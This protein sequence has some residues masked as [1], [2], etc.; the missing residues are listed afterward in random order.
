MDDKHFDRISR[1][2]GGDATRRGVLGMAAALTGLAVTDA[3]AKSK[4]RKRR[5]QRRRK[6]PGSPET[7]QDPWLP[8]PEGCA[9]ICEGPSV[10]ESL[11][12]VC[13]ASVPGT[14]C[15]KEE[16]NP[17]SCAETKECPHGQVCAV[18]ECLRLC[19]PDD[20]PE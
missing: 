14:V 1:L 8:V 7:C 2:L 18:N 3:E 13:R 19:Q 15:V 17:A 9:R 12:C 5:R 6:G 4:R 20:K 10:C 11:G 16:E